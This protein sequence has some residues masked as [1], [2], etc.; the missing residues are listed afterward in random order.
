MFPEAVEVT[1]GPLKGVDVD[2][3]D[4]PDSVQT[5]AAVAMFAKGSTRVRNVKNLRVKETDRIAAI[6][7][8]CSKLGAVV[9]EKEDGF[10]LTPPLK[11][12]SGEIETYKDH[13]M[14]MSF[15]VVGVAVPGILIKDPDVVSKSFPGFFEQLGTLGI[16]ARRS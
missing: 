16:K 11:V 8:E 5:L 12:G 6:A 15:A 13:R 7:K 1:G 10:V 9:E 2:M 4:C 14:A 3:N